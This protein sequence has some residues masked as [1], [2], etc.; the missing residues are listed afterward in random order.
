MGPP[1]GGRS[2]ITM[3]LQR[4]YNV[5]TYTNLGRDSID[6]MFKTVLRHFLCMFDVNV[7]TEI[8]N[9][10]EASTDVFSKVGESLRPRPATSHYLFNLRDMAKII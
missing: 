5:L 3:R 4:H 10:V 8:D 9:I 6:I 7:Q 2:K 1:G